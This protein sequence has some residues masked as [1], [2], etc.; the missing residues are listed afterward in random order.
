MID[1]EMP[2]AA[3][4]T[5]AKVISFGAKIHRIHVHMVRFCRRAVSK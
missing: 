5:R 1:F 3:K 4:I 2:E